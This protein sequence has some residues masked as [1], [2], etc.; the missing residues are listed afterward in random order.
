MP[1]F[2]KTEKKRTSMKNLIYSFLMIFTLNLVNGQVCQIPK[3]LD[4]EIIKASE[5]EKFTEKDFYR[6][7]NLLFE[8]EAK[9]SLNTLIVC[10]SY[11][12][13][14]ATLFNS[15]NDKKRVL[16]YR[17]IG[18]AQDSLF[19]DEL[20]NRITSN[21]S[22]LLKTWSS[23]ALMANGYS[24]ASNDLFIL[25]SSYPEGLP[26]D[27]LINMFIQ[28]DKIAVKKTCWEFIDSENKNQQIMAIQCLANFE[29]DEK[30]QEKLLKFLNN[31]DN[32]SKGW[33]ISS[34]SMQKMENL[35][36]ILERYVEIGNL[37]GVII[38]AL[39]NSPTKT[40]NKFAKE[41]EKKKN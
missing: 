8:Y 5:N 10:S 26:V 40:D 1:N 3:L 20:I 9:D 11:S 32:D 38:R 27:I 13:N 29:K 6:V 21:E 19:N 7:N 41:L 24:K 25:F 37:K 22:S 23:T 34:I 14:I 30:L 4:S 18:V 33:V 15:G 2:R 39:E 28:Y 36:P 12:Q 35:K 17:L 16:A 31:W